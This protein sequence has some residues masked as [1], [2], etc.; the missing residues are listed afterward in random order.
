MSQKYVLSH[1]AQAR[2][3]VIRYILLVG[4]L[5]LVTVIVQSAVLSR[6]RLF[7]VC[8]DLALCVVMCLAY[9]GGRQLGA[10]CGI[11]LGAMTEALCAP[12]ITLLPLFYLFCGYLAGHYARVIIPRTLTAFSAYFGISLLLRAALTVLCACMTYPTVHL[13]LLLLHTVLPELLLTGALGFVIY[14][15]MQLF[16]GLLEKR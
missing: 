8:P 12:G 9:F 16:Y 7:D 4:V 14:Y 13:P 5:V 2:S 11:V 3:L 15:P 1:R 10:I 6:Y